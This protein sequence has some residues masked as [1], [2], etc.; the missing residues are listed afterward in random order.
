MCGGSGAWGGGSLGTR[1]QKAKR[2]AGRSVPPF[3]L[4]PHPPTTNTPTPPPPIKQTPLPPL[5]LPCT[6]PAAAS[7]QRGGGAK[8]APSLPTPKARQP[9]EGWAEAVEVASS[10]GV[11]LMVVERAEVA[12]GAE[13][14]PPQPSGGGG[15]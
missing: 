13:G 6:I 8:G 12:K 5:H 9:E 1:V 15:S 7:P 11:K 3:P 4:S 2:E 14:A 10:G